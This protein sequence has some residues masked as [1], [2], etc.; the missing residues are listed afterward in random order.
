MRLALLGMRTS[1]AIRKGAVLD[2]VIKGVLINCAGLG[3]TL[4]GLQ[5]GGLRGLPLAL[6]LAGCLYAHCPRGCR[7]GSHTA[8]HALPVVRCRWGASV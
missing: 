1:V 6:P 7:W 4:L 8:P 5:V 3:A 2:M